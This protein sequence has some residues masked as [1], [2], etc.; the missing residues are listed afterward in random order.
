MS[1]WKEL[2][3]YCVDSGHAFV[4]WNEPVTDELPKPVGQL[5]ACN[6]KDTIRLP[7][8]EDAGFVIHPFSRED[9]LPQLFFPARTYLREDKPEHWDRINDSSLGKHSRPETANETVFKPDYLSQV[10]AFKN[11]I[12]EGNVSK[13]IASRVIHTDPIDQDDWSEL[14]L[15][16]VEQYPSAFKYLFFHPGAGM[17]MGATPEVLLCGREEK[18]ETISLA[19]TL[20]VQEDGHYDWTEKEQ[21]EHQWVSDFIEQ[22]LSSAL[23][24][25]VVKTP[26]ETLITG[27]VAHLSTRFT[28]R[29]GGSPLQLADRLHP[30]PAISG[31]PVDA[32]MR[33]IQKH[34]GHSR[35]YYTGFLGKL[36]GK[37]D[38]RL[39]VNLR[40]MRLDTPRF[41]IFVG[42]GIT[43]LSNP[44]EEWLETVEKSK[45]LL[46]VIEQVR[47]KT[48][49]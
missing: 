33:L 49:V 29:Y 30:T 5:I 18:Y 28:F 16:L 40:C 38:T 20:P 8:E 4:T 31:Y 43:D 41:E 7:K 3:Q 10:N 34:E 19:G 13:V 2:I 22:N 14:Y 48:T 36:N 42:G 39:Y 23:A 9:Q 12:T 15:E 37:K 6:V 25:E 17:W 44:E 1:S 35:G 46:D 47:T 24:Q 21:V 32:A 27:P 45:T 26:V 11:E